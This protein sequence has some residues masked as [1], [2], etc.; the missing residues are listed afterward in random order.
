MHSA[1]LS[2]DIFRKQ[3]QSSNCFQI[4]PDLL[5]HS[6]LLIWLLS[7]SNSVGDSGLPFSI[8]SKSLCKYA[9]T[10]IC[11]V[12]GQHEPAVVFEQCTPNVEEISWALWLCMIH[13]LFYP[14]R[15]KGIKFTDLGG[16]RTSKELNCSYIF[17]RRV[18]V[19]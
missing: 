16:M 18:L 17:G 11:F 6:D 1:D 9:F 3:T 7:R 12:I 4:Q 15:K 2:L 19:S 14:L 5:I 10:V 8:L 13:L